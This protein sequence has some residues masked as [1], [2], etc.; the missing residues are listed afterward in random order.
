M[1][2]I[3]TDS[4]VRRIARG[5]NTSP[6]N[7]RF[8]SEVLDAINDS[9]SDLNQRA[10]LS[11]EVSLVDSLGDAEI[12]IDQKYER[13]L[14]DG[15]KFFMEKNTPRMGNAPGGGVEVSE[16]ENRWHDAVDMYYT[17]ALHAR[18]ATATN[19]IV[20]LGAPTS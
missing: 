16:L 1:A 10:D 14:V 6:E 5:M 4:F 12:G 8:T 13:L 9:I 18:Q 11:T 20:G 15:V 7:D 3:V 2:N 19:D 17:D